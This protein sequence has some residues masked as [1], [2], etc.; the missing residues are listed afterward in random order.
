MNCGDDRGAEDA[1]EQKN[2]C[3]QQ[4][5]CERGCRSHSHGD[6]RRLKTESP[7]LATGSEEK[8]KGESERGRRECLRVCV[9]EG[10]RVCER[11]SVWAGD[12]Q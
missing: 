5:D 10:E 4:N 11:A 3:R 8:F 1:Q 9:R 12:G 7:G 2:E 6:G